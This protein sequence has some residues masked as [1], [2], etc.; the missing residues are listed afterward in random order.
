MKKLHTY[1]APAVRPIKFYMEGDLLD[2][3]YSIVASSHT[4][5]LSNKRKFDDMTNS[6]RSSI[7]DTSGADE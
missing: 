1:S 2:G 5:Q 7:W 6:G 3:G 4:E